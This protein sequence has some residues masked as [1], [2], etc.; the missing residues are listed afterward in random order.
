MVVG[1]VT[2]SLVAPRLELRELGCDDL[3]PKQ[4]AVIVVE[5]ARGK[6]E[7]VKPLR[8]R[9]RAVEMNLV[10]LLRQVMGIALR[11]EGSASAEQ[12]RIAEQRLERNDDLLPPERSARAAIDASGGLI[13]PPRGHILAAQRGRETVP[14]QPTCISDQP[15]R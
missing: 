15:L 11:F 1:N 6:R 7:L 9:L 14:G 3:M 10:L 5:E 12:Q 13:E 8:R 4:R 2:K